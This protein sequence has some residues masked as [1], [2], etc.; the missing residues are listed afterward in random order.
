MRVLKSFSYKDTILRVCCKEFEALT[1]YIV[2]QRKI[3]EEYISKNPLFRKTLV[4]WPKDAMAPEVILRMC[5]AGQIAHVGPMASV[6]GTLAQMGV[7]HSIKN[8]CKEAIV[9]NGGDLFLYSDKTV[10][11]GIFAGQQFLE[12]HLAFVIEPSCMP[13]ALC[14]S[15]SKMGHSMS[16]GN[17]DLV[18]VVSENASLADAVATMV[19][20]KIKKVEDMQSIVQDALDQCGVKGI[21]AVK[22][23]KVVLCGDLPSM[24]KCND[25]QIINKI[26]S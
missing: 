9:N 15:S 16:L 5:E 18:T 20:N 19:C 7:E 25:E 14:S 11:V 21:L 8:G 17:C 24:V 1:K 13:V 23:D 12:S 4:P 26:V 3:I 6:A 22:S 2:V 10:Y